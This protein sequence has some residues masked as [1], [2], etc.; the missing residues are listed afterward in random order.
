[1][2]LTR[3]YSRLIHLKEST[4]LLNDG[5]W[6]KALELDSYEPAIKIE[7]LTDQEFVDLVLKEM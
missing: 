7:E 1:M 3:R 6:F 4:L 2:E 5:K